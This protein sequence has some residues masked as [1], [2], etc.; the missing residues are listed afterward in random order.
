MPRST[1]A[2]RPGA[3]DEARELVA[4]VASLSDAG[5]AITAQAVSSRLG[6]SPERAEKL[7]ELVLTSTGSDGSRLPLVEEDGG[8]T[9]AF[10]LG[11]RGRR[12]RLTRA[13]TIALEAA[14]ERLGVSDDDPI[15]E[16]LRE[17]VSV[18]PVDSDL[19][20]RLLGGEV[21]HG[22]SEKIAACAQALATRHDL[23]FFYHKDEGEKD[24]ER[25]VSPRGLRHEDETWYLDAHDLV[26]EGERTFRLDRMSDLESRPRSPERKGAPRAARLVRITFSDP[27]YLDLLP[28]HD[29]RVTGRDERS[30]TVS[31]QT[32]YYG[33][34]WLP[35]M[36]AACGGTAAVDDP[37]VKSLAL[38]Y[39][40]SMAS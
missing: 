9:L 8:F 2:G 33:G 3:L 30:G 16:R 14:L 13:E 38:D 27:R 39:A 6:V 12:L 28:W 31:A 11:M 1:S 23:A 4:L 5:D 26:R 7:V 15:R 40:R 34:M 36:L 35:R 37:E 18:D 17:S 25:L 24:E 10:S 21:E 22:L 19:V 32:E 29:L 20:E